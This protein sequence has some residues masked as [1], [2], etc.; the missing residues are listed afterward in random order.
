MTKQN[1]PDDAQWAPAPT[2]EPC[3]MRMYAFQPN[4]IR[5]EEYF[6]FYKEKILPWLEEEGVKDAKVWTVERD[7][8]FIFAIAASPVDP[9]W[10]EFPG[11]KGFLDVIAELRFTPRPE[12][13]IS[14]NI[15]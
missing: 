9:P 7:N 4:P 10:D 14:P 6:E 3:S 2:N 1:I 5:R 15:Y 13:G 8:I 12:L 11:L